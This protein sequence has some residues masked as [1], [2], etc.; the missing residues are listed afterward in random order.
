VIGL[1]WSG[2]TIW[3]S[4]SPASTDHP[5]YPAAARRRRRLRPP[6]ADQSSE[7]TMLVQAIPANA[8]WR[9][10]PSA[11]SMRWTRRRLEYQQRLS[12]VLQLAAAAL[13]RSRCM[14]P[15]SAC[16][17]CSDQELAASSASHAEELRQRNERSAKWCCR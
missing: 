17:A 14:V 4:R 3:A 12:Y 13:G 7:P 5:L 2:S 16:W 1:F 11:G 10:W 8:D 6:S 9:C 15:L